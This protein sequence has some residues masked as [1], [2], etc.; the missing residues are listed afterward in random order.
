MDEIVSTCDQFRPGHYMTI[1]KDTTDYT[2][3]PYFEYKYPLLDKHYEG[4][5]TPYVSEMSRVFFESK[6]KKLLTSAVDKRLMS[7]RPIGCLLSGGLDS[8]LVTALVA[9]HYPRGKLK[10]FSI[11]LPCL[12]YTSPSPRDS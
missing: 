6:I 10:T 4:E 11:G 8:S 9:K 2:P 7:E 5:P 1:H 3:V 12:L